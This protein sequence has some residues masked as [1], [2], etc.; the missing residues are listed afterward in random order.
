MLTTVMNARITRKITKTTLSEN[1]SCQP[2]ARNVR[3][4]KVAHP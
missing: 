2:Q 3:W 4:K 1:S